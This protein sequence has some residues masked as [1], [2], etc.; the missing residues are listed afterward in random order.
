MDRGD[1]KRTLTIEPELCPWLA[2]AVARFRYLYPNVHLSISDQSVTLAT[3]DDQ[4]PAL[5]QD[6]MF[7]L[8]RQKIY[9]ETLPL[10]TMLIEGVTG[11]ASRSA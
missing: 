4:M 1:Y 3:S 7:C 9:S 11:F 5:V 2:D 10:R 8:Y 6:F